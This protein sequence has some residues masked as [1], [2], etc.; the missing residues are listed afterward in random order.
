MRTAAGARVLSYPAFTRE[1]G[2]PSDTT[3]NSVCGK[4]S[5]L[6]VRLGTAA[7]FQHSSFASFSA[8]DGLPPGPSEAAWAGFQL[9]RN[10]V[11]ARIE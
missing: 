2:K 6:T 11:R 3:T 10:S 9:K 8:V 5:D 1:V 7:V 4:M